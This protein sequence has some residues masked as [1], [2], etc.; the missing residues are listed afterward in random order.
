MT[1]ALPDI[2][3]LLTGLAQW[4]G[5]LVY[6]TL[7]PRR[8]S[9]P[10]TVGVIV[11]GL[12]LLVGI[13]LAADGLP[14]GF[15]TPMM[16]LSVVAMFGFVHLVGAVTSSESGYLT[17]RGFVLAELVAS[18]GWQLH[19]FFFS[20]DPGYLRPGP[21]ALL[22]AVFV[23]GFGVAWYAERRHFV[24]YTAHLVGR[25]NLSLSLAIALIT[26]ALSNLSFVVTNTPFSGTVPTDVFYIRT[27]VDLCGFVAL[28]AQQEQ[29]RQQRLDAELATMNALLRSQHE[30]YLTSE[31]DIERANTAAHDLKHQIALL[32]SELDPEA[33]SAHLDELEQVTD[34]LGTQHHTGNSVV[35]TVL[36]TKARVAGSH[37]ITLTAVADGTAVSHLSAMDLATLLGNALDNA[38]ESTSRVPDVD[39]RL[40]RVA[41]FTQGAFAIMR[42]EN[43]FDGVLRYED[44]QLATRKAE[45]A[46]HG[47]GLKSIQHTAAKYDGTAAVTTNDSWFTLTVLIPRPTE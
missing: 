27:L 14:L 38:I 33:R 9:R 39:R 21:G 11:A 2:P 29:L 12:A 17:L 13:Q 18:L 23:T 32:R 30:Q 36:T 20:A 1:E 28:Y 44:G 35:D 26:F 24:P 37:E 19:L 45:R 43:Y 7:V 34:S 41:I 6:L 5:C 40:I 15:W 3:R 46:A 42:F 25:R 47:F 31:R 8:F 10:G 4:A 22:A 16:A